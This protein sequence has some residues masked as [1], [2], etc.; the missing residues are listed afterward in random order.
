MASVAKGDGSVLLF[1]I[2]TFFKLFYI[3]I[4]K[5]FKEPLLILETHC[6]TLTPFMGVSHLAIPF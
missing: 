5:Q 2:K 6:K 3:Y 4:K 1:I